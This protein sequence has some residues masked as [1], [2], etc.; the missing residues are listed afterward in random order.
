MFSVGK[1]SVFGKAFLLFLR[2]DLNLNGSQRIEAQS[3]VKLSCCGVFT[4]TTSF[5]S[6][7]P[8]SLPSSCRESNGYLSDSLT[9]SPAV[10][11]DP[12]AGQQQ[13]DTTTPHYSP[14][15][16]SAAAQQRRNSSQQQQ[17]TTAQQNQQHH[18][19]SSLG[20][21][22]DHHHPPA[23]QHR[24]LGPTLSAEN[25]SVQQ[26]FLET[27]L[28]SGGQAPSEQLPAG[29]GGRKTSSHSR[30]AS[31]GTREA[32]RLVTDDRHAHNN[33][34]SN[35]NNNSKRADEEGGKQKKK[36]GVIA[37]LRQSFRRASKKSPR[38]QAV[39]SSSS[40]G[41]GGRTS[42]NS[43]TATT[44]QA[45]PRARGDHQAASPRF[46]SPGEEWRLKESYSTISVA[47]V[48]AGRSPPGLTVKP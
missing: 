36:L 5:P 39:E 43:L 40:V 33:S 13:Q 1:L 23:V 31:L 32:D 34:N 30:Q 17:A 15:N 10:S 24:P 2:I 6:P 44:P 38:Q 21:S 26:L 11:P 22:V 48:K 37:A 27:V 42:T 47:S 41:F 46:S 16:S 28:R 25:N 14:H 20:Q 9:A 3:Y 35:N 12:G 8:P 29:R 18:R 7:P 45:T 4:F 19:N